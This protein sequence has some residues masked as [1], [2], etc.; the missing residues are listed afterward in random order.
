MFRWHHLCVNN[1]NVLFHKKPSE[2]SPSHWENGAFSPAL[3]RAPTPALAITSFAWII[4]SSSCSLA[5]DRDEMLCNFPHPGS[6]IT[7]LVFS[8]DAVFPLLA[9]TKLASV[10]VAD[11]KERCGSPLIHDPGNFE[12]NTH[13]LRQTFRASGDNF[14]SAENFRASYV[15]RWSSLLKGKWRTV[16]KISALELKTSSRASQ[17]HLDF[18]SLHQS[19]YWLVRVWSLHPII[20]QTSD[21][22]YF[23]CLNFM[24]IN[25]AV[26]INLWKYTKPNF[27][28]KINSGTYVQLQILKVTSL[29]YAKQNPVK[30]CRQLK[31]IQRF[32]RDYRQLR[33]TRQFATLSMEIK[34]FNIYFR[35]QQLWLFS[36][37]FSFPPDCGSPR[38]IE[39][40]PRQGTSLTPLVS[41]WVRRARRIVFPE[42]STLTRLQLQS[43]LLFPIKSGSAMIICLRR[44]ERR[45]SCLFIMFCCDFY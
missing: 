40:S 33:T 26:F 21:L 7:F 45:R 38:E 36:F 4:Y 16:T 14:R 39:F 19:W 12:A 17:S 37:L 13:K 9:P 42:H 31:K 11:G 24:H 34:N 15:A 43:Q 35:T 2:N 32:S 28:G 8:L 22:K 20:Q 6:A 23:S 29:N 10:Y 5:W 1:D 3:P 44:S 18:I 30:V 27:P 41:W 25:R